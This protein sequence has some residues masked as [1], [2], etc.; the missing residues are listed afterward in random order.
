ME[1]LFYNLFSL[2]GHHYETALPPSLPCSDETMQPPLLTVTGN[3]NI[4]IACMTALY[5]YNSR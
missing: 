1:N 4:T 3:S 5:Y 2:V